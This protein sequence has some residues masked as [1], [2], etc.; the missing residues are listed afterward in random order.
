[1]VLMSH[2]NHGNSQKFLFVLR[3]LLSH[4]EITEITE[5]YRPTDSLISHRF[6]RFH[7]FFIVLRTF[8]CP[9]EMKE[10]KEIIASLSMRSL[11]RRHFL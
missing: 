2:R 7:R 1:M 11:C 8:Y 3:T 4:T 10:I 6:H 5:I 9:A